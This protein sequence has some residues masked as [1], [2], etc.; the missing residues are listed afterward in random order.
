MNSC[1]I[2]DLK[3][4]AALS[5]SSRVVQHVANYKKRDGVSGPGSARPSNDLVNR[6][7][8]MQTCCNVLC[9]PLMSCLMHGF[10][11]VRGV[12]RVSAKYSNEKRLV[13][14]ISAPSTWTTAI[15]VSTFQSAA[16]HMH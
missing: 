7:A 4:H 3:A 8:D 5:L 6:Q 10:K 14:K 2:V 9:H 15:V 11:E 12:V 1:T 16:Y 13:G